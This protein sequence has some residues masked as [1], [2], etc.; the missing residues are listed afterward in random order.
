VAKAEQP[1]IGEHD[2]KRRALE[3]AL[4]LFGRKGYEATSMREI[5]EAA[6]VTKATLYYHFE[7]KAAIIRGLAERYRQALDDL[8]LW[9]AQKPRPAP[10]VVLGAIA[11]LVRAQ[12]VQFYRFL[13]NNAQAIRDFPLEDSRNFEIPES[14][15]DAL[16]YPDTSIEA[17]IRAHMAV[18]AIHTSLIIARGLGATDEEILRTTLQISEEILQL[19]EDGTR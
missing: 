10:S 1:P 8:A 5:A 17:R 4:D 18:H 2:T 9:A 6:G 13:Y 12:G 15:Y 11:D 7:N 16:V 19:T 3:I 14:L